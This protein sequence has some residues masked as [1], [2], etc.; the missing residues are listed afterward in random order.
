MHPS[1]FVRWEIWIGD[2]YY[3]S[4]YK[5]RA[6]LRALAHI[7]EGTIARRLAHGPRGGGGAPDVRPFASYKGAVEGKVVAWWSPS[8]VDGMG[9]TRS[10]ESQDEP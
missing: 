2:V 10:A 5:Q 9:Y 8:L 1:E 7:D 6:A 3:G 4:Y